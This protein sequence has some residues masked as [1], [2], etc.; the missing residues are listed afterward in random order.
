MSH[1]KSNLRDIEFNMFEVSDL[2]DHLGSTTFPD[3]DT[4][5]ISD[6]LREVDR[7]AGGA[8][9]DSFVDADRNPPNQ[10]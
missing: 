8:W 3:F 2:P 4:H 5:S 6:I 1:Y 9:A 7:L 10:R